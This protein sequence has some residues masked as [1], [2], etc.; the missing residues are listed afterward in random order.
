MSESIELVVDESTI[1]S[2]PIVANFPEIEKWLTENL[3][4]YKNLVVTEDTIAEGK[5]VKAKINRLSKA[6]SDRRIAVKKRYLQPFEDFEANAKRL[7]GICDEVSSNIDRQIKVFDE[8]KKQEKRDALEAYF[9]ETVGE[10]HE[11]V[12]FDSIFNPRWLNA[13]YSEDQAHDDIQTYL[14]KIDNGVK[15]IRELHSDFEV[16]LL[17]HFYQSRDLA[18][19]LLF[20]TSLEQQ[21]AREEERKAAEEA[22]RVAE[23]AAKAAQE[24]AKKPQPLPQGDDPF[25]PQTP[26]ETVSAPAENEPMLTLRFEVTGTKAQLTTLANYMKTIGIKPKRI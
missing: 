20:K 1:Q 4:V 23:A 12:S 9:N 13:T 18:Q 19:T 21:K 16:T 24:A 10:Y 14:S 22:R 5:A 25:E 6:I 3:A 26:A 11:V 15:A 7:C 17:N 8:R 2:Q